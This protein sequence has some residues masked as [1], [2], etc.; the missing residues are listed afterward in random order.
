MINRR[1]FVQNSGAAVAGLFTAGPPL[2]APAAAPLGANDDIR[3][4]VIGFNAH[5][6]SHIRA[7][8]SMPGVRL[9]ALCDVDQQVLDREAS[10]LAG[11]GIRVKKYRDLRKLLD[12]PD[13]DAVSIVTPNHWHAL[14]TVWACQADKDVCVEKP[15]SHSIWEGRKMVEA[16]RKYDRIVQADLDN[17]CRPNLDEAFAYLRSGE[18]GKIVYARAYDYKRRTS[19]GNV[20]GPQKVPSHVDFNLWT[21]PAPLRPL[22]R[23]FLHY[24]WHW[25]WDTGNGEICNNGSHKLDQVRWALG[26]SQ[27]PRSVLSF[28]GRYGYTDDGQTPNTLV[29]IYDYDGIPVIYEARGL[30]ESNQSENMD[31]FRAAT[32]TGQSVSHPH[33]DPYANGGCA[34]FCEGGYYFER[35]IYDNDGRRMKRFEGGGGRGPQHN[36]IVAVNSRKLSDLKTDIAEGHASAMF[37]HMGNVSYLCGESMSFEK[38]QPLVAIHDHAEQAF[39]RMTSHLRDNGIDIDRQPVVVGPQLTF[40]ADR[41]RFTGQHSQR[42][43]LFLKD[44]YREPFVIGDEV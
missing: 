28:G 40:D 18:I 17:R 12:D 23:E 5:G 32:A 6:R 41:E 25:Q 22:L 44:T 31:S 2:L 16:A 43:N 30:S 19:L 38:A 34:I 15:I 10:D 14:A 24:D 4:A 8:R 21:G 35:A 29:A 3:V 11:N 37:C 26:K 9:V 20:V 1:Q 27:P 42:A 36:F 13:I 39:E 33:D 7:Y